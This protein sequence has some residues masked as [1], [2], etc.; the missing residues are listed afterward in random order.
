M[1]KPE[2]F[3]DIEHPVLRAYN[4]TMT[5]LTLYRENGGDATAEYLDGFAEKERMAIVAMLL[6]YQKDPNKVRQQ[7]RDIAH[8]N[9][10]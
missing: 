3:N 4:R 8:E 7:V 9:L 2:V 5:A 1:L 6:S 10:Q